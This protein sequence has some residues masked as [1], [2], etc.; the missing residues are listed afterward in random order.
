[1]I[2]RRLAYISIASHPMGD[3][4]LRALLKSCRHANSRLRISGYLHYHQGEFIQVLEGPETSVGECF[5][6]I[7]HDTRHH[8]IRVLFDERTHRRTFANWSM[9]CTC[10]TTM[11]PSLLRRVEAGFDKLRSL[12]HVM[13]TQVLLLFDQLMQTGQLHE[14]A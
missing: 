5:E 10:E 9:G 6:R 11:P 3:P 12:D 7:K 4:E 1:M 13:S 14:A 8:N 2:L